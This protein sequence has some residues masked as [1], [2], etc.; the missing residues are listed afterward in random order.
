MV[1]E[2]GHFALIWVVVSSTLS[3]I[4]YAW[5]KQQK[6]E[7]PLSL[8]CVARLNGLLASLSL[9]ILAVLFMQDQFQ[10]DYVASHSN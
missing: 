5:Q 3:T 7:Q 9:F 8:S 10:Y 6:I 2:W 4:Y 1:G